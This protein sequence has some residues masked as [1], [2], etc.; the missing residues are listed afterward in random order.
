MKGKLWFWSLTGP[1]IIKKKK[2]KL[3]QLNTRF[4]YLMKLREKIN[5]GI[6]SLYLTGEEN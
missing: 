1:F 5:L 2:K 4:I 6:E 3:S